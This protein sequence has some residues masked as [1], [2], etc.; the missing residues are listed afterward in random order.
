M[1]ETR[2]YSLVVKTDTSRHPMFSSLVPCYSP[3]AL[4]NEQVKDQ[5]LL[6]GMWTFAGLPAVAIH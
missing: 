2:D 4:I 6:I 3:T 5:P 1:S